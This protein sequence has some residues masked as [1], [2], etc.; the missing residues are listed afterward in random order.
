MTIFRADLLKGKRILVTGGGTGLGRE[1]AGEYAKLGAEVYICGRRGAVVAETAR[2]LAETHNTRVTPIECDIRLPDAVE[3]MMTR[4]FDEG[5]LTGLVNNAAGNFISRT[6]DL[7]PNGFNAIA[8]IVFHGTF[9]V[10]LAAGKRWIEARQQANV[11]SILTTSVWNGGPFTVPSAMSKA[12]INVMTR[13]LAVEWAPHGIRLNAIAPG[14][15]PTK[16]AGERLNPGSIR[17][18]TMDKAHD[19]SAI[20]NP[21]GR[22]GRMQ[23]LRNLATFLMADGCDY[24]TGETIV[25]D[26][27]AFLGGGG[28][29][30]WQLS[31]LGDQDWENIRNTIKGANEK[32][33][34]K[35]TA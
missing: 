8:S 33:K 15:F 30:F 25:I 22:V 4:V 14:L 31:H 29:T 11:V 24:V 7:S 5:P 9:Y 13:S 18:T 28:G 3:N 26:G 27:G 19:S 32:D 34:A 6:K 35:R 17:A 21:M 23:E 1:I 20:N 16:G 10:T 2:E 12:G